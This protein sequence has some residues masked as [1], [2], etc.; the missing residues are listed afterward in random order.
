MKVFCL[1]ESLAVYPMAFE[2]HLRCSTHRFAAQYRPVSGASEAG[3]YWV[4]FVGCSGATSRGAKDFINRELTFA[5]PE[6]PGRALSPCLQQSCTRTSLPDHSNRSF[7]KCYWSGEL[8][9]RL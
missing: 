6:N 8:R 7:E 4:F 5:W 9:R 1:L 2:S 3:P